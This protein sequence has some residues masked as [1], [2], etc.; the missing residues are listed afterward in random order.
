MLSFVT[1]HNPRQISLDTHAIF[2]Q[3]SQTNHVARENGLPIPPVPISPY[4]MLKVLTFMLLS[5]VSFV[6]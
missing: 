4:S 2:K 3:L 5:I 1:S 6:N